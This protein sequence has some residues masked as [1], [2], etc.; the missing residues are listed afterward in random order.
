MSGGVGAAD[1]IDV[2]V[3]AGSHLGGCAAVV[4]AR[5]LQTIDARNVEFA[6]LNAGG[7]QH[8]VT[9]QLG[10]VV[11]AHIAIRTIHP[12]RRRFL[13]RD[14]LYAKT[15]GLRNGTAREVAAREA[16]RKAQVVFNARSSGQLVRP[17]L[18]FQS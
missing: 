13:R 11:E 16:R 2:L 1:D 12:Q 9:R 8:G 3:P 10:S 18:R 5:A 17:A 15:P 7:Q 4:N 6:P 14:D